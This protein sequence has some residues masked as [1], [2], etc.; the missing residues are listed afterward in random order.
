MKTDIMSMFHI[1]LPNVWFHWLPVFIRT[2]VLGILCGTI[3]C[4]A[5]HSTVGVTEA[6]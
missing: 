2:Y 1:V 4:A 5:F 6:H 3:L